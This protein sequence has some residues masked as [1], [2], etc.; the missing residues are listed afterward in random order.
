MTDYLIHTITDTASGSARYVIAP[1]AV[2]LGLGLTETVTARRPLADAFDAPVIIV[3]RRQPIDRQLRAQLESW[4]A[5]QGGS[6]VAIDGDALAITF[7]QLG[8]A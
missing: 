1:D 4:R 8:D 7:F 5:G 3:S 2:T 6:P